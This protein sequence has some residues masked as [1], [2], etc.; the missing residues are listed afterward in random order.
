M[1][2]HEYLKHLRVKKGLS[3]RKLSELIGKGSSYIS[4]LESG[5]SAKLDYYNVSAILEQLGFNNDEI[6]QICEEYD[7]ELPEAAKSEVRFK[8]KITEDYVTGSLFDFVDKRAEYQRMMDEVHNVL[9]HLA[10]ADFE[11]KDEVLTNFHELIMSMGKDPDKFD[12]FV[13]MFKNKL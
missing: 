1:E 6:Q 4:A 9:Q 8:R 2:L 10:V 5:R 11:D 13:D 12:T 7:I 3:S